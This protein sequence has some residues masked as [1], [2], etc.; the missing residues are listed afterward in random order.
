MPK[1][2]TVWQV[3]IPPTYQWIVILVSRALHKGYPEQDLDC[4][5]HPEVLPTPKS[6]FILRIMYFKCLS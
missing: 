2:F 4:D 5:F 1:Y 3:L 6:G